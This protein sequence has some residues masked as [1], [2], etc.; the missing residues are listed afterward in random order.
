MVDRSV[1]FGGRCVFVRSL[2]A[3]HWSNE[4]PRTTNN[5]GQRIA[6]SS[7][8]SAAAGGA[9]GRPNRVAPSIA[10]GALLEHH[11]L[12][13]LYELCRLTLYVVRT[14]DPAFEPGR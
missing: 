10:A 5:S 6:T 12:L 14:A 9:R 7:G 11:H 1:R 2:G 13:F 4:C 3:A 8:N